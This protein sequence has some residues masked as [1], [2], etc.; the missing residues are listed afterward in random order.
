LGE[1]EYIADAASETLSQEQTRLGQ[2]ARS[3][4][5]L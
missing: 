1:A 2:M 5:V 3:S 4:I